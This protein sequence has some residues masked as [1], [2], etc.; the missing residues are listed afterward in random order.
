MRF[1]DIPLVWLIQNL[2]ALVAGV[3]VLR[4]AARREHRLGSGLQFPGLGPH[5]R[6][7]ERDPSGRT[8]VVQT[9][10]L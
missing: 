6:N 8:L 7:R 1:F 9:L 3:L 2:V 4:Y 5:P 10:R